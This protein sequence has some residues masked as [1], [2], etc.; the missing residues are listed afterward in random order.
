MRLKAHL[1]GVRPFR[2]G[3]AAALALGALA[4]W[5][6]LV[7]PGMINTRA[8]GDS[9][10]LLLR[11]YELQV[12]LRA[13]QF[14][15]RW[16]PDAAY[17]LGYPFFNYYASL[18]YYLGAG[19][20]LAG[21]GVLAALKL[22]QL[23]GFLAA[24]A[25][26]YALAYALFADPAAAFLAAAAYTFAPFHMVNVYV[27]GDSLSEFYAFA[28][29]PL[30]LW[31][32]V[33]LQRSPSAGR[34]AVLA[35]AYAGL[36]ITHN[37]SAFI[38]TPLV[39]AALLWAAASAPRA[40]LRVL[41]AGAVAL[42]LGA[43]LSAWFWG[44]AL[45]ER[46]AVSLAEMTT[47]YFDYH[48]HFLS[49]NL[50]QPRLLFDYAI[51]GQRTPFVVGGLQAGLAA[52]GLITLIA[53]WIWQRRLRWLDLG[54][55]A[56]L[57]YAIWPITPG[58]AP[59]WA[60]VPLL[61]LVQFPWRFLSIA[62]VATALVAAAGLSRCAWR[63]W[64]AAGLVLALA[65][66]ALALL[67]PEPMPL[68]ERDVT[69][70]R[71]Q[72]YE[73]LTGN[74]G[75]TIRAEYLPQGANPRPFTSA[76]LLFGEAHPS[77]LAAEG[78][79]ESARLLAAEP[80]RQV[81]EV[82]VAPPR[83]QLVFQTYAFPGWEA[84]IDG[85][86][87]SID[88]RLANGRIALAVAAGR[89]QVVLRLGRTPLRAS[90]E[91]LS[92]GAALLIAGLGFVALLRTA[93]AWRGVA[94]TLTIVAATVGLG[95]LLGTAISR[96][97]TANP[98][99]E[100][101]DFGRL[102]YLH[103]NPNGVA[104]GSATRLLGYEISPNPARAGD[105]LRVRLRWQPPS[106]ALRAVVRLTTAAEPLFHAPSLAASQAP[107][108]ATTEHE[109]TVP[110]EVAPGL[111]LLAVEVE[112]PQGPIGPRT[113]QGAGLSTIYLAP[114]RVLA[115]PP[116]PTQPAL[117]HLGESVDILQ[118][119][120]RQDRAGVI[121]IHLT[122]RAN[123]PLP[124]DYIASLRL[125]DLNGLSVAARDAQPRYQLYPT[126]LWPVGTPV[127]D[128]CDLPVPR[129]TPPGE[130]YEVEAVLYRAE[131]REP[132]GALRIAKV[133]L[134]EPTV[135]A[136]APVLQS[137]AGS[138][139]V[140]A[141]RVE[142][143]EVQDGEEVVAPVQ[144]T[145]Q[146]AP[147]PNLVCRLSLQ[148]EQGS[149]VAARQAPISPRYPPSQW[150]QHAL[151]NDRLALRVAP[152]TTSGRY[153][154]YMEILAADGRSL[155]RWRAPGSIV[156]K[157][158]PRQTTLPAF[159]HA[160]GVDLGGVIRLAG[161]DLE[162]SAD[163]IVL[164]LHW[165]ALRAP[166]RDYKVFLHCIDTASEEIVTQRDAQPLDNTYPTGRWAAGEVVSD[167]LVLDMAK[168]PAGRYQL[169]IGLYDPTTNDR[170]EPTGNPAIISNGRVMLE[171]V[172]WE[173]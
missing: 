76:S 19:L 41:L 105:V 75:S 1:G 50:V 127:A 44:P 68:G 30:L 36:M 43:A 124:E 148:N 53:S 34:L 100:T 140:T 86:P 48:G 114:V 90:A 119:S 40:R 20:S 134:S 172:E 155:G 138:L 23:L 94:L 3:L 15:A 156:V 153:R 164:T 111:A 135:D 93:G 66:S 139:G 165:Q 121:S 123:T 26:M 115:P 92:L 54:L 35:L 57:A 77:P 152:G 45:L 116:A 91:R 170:L 6:L 51:D 83:A 102:P 52:L 149:E 61:P 122:W 8:G 144:W 118:A 108:A 5:P 166:G 162:R 158:A 171:V 67:R 32:I 56:V 129:G 117:G 96:A 70:E 18:P 169:A 4:A 42:V 103:P 38:F 143:L 167:R 101:M 84:T 87:A 120:A 49:R 25:A 136:S 131:T 47:G 39:G 137:F 28:F 133:T 147:L 13:G 145:A 89:H 11:L 142:R 55:L 7:V 151:V 146:S 141:W 110:P 16:M 161:Y 126:S 128:Y 163:Q 64:I 125:L 97:A 37:I 31:S 33:R 62:A 58:S 17:G 46:G 72:L 85:E 14:P 65:V 63:G 82:T 27:R 22:V 9:P 99:C 2:I 159:A 78:S 112:G 60:R 59:L 107:L 24:A 154:L 98:A 130:G 69:P 81:W 71:L 29:Y 95:A 80:T 88:S 79:L 113:D 132:L 157:S 104:F 150:P 160:V 12:N 21:A 109:L 10:F 173:K 168:V 74:V 106:G 73:H